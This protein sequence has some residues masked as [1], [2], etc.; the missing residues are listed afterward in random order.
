MGFLSWIGKGLKTFFTP[1]SFK[2][3]EKFENYVRKKIFTDRYFELIQRTYGYN[4]KKNKYVPSSN[5]DFKL[6]DRRTSKTFYA[7]VKYRKYFYKGKV[8]W[9][10]EEQLNHYRQCNREAPVFIILGIGTVPHRPEFVFLVPLKVANFTQ[11]YFSEIRKYRIH[12][13]HSLTSKR[14][15]RR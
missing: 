4:E 13:R 7:E 12:P 11:F 3:G 14:L 6:R 15:W 10:T 5:P 8:T 1:E 9:C 2:T